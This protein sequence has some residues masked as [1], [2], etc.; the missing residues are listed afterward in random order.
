MDKN[1]LP[2]ACKQETLTT[3]VG[4]E[5][6]VFN[7]ATD[8]ASCLNK[9]TAAVWVACDGKTSVSRLLQIISQAGFPDASEEAVCLAIDELI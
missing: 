3:T 2:I 4:D 5:L 7:T 6:V 1:S 8:T 9:F